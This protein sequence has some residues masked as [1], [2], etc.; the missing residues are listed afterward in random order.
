MVNANTVN[1][2]RGAVAQAMRLCPV[3]P[4]RSSNRTCGFPAS[5]FPAG[6]TS[7]LSAYGLTIQCQAVDAQ[8][9][10]DRFV[11]EASSASRGH[12]VPPGKKTPHV[13][14]HVGVDTPGVHSCGFRSR[15]SC[16]SRARSRS[17]RP[18]YPARREWDISEMIANLLLKPG[19]TLRRRARPQI[20]FAIAPM[21]FKR[22]ATA[23][24]Y[25]SAAGQS[26]S[27]E[28][29]TVPAVRP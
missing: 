5:G 6:F 14:H 22:R 19:D 24:R 10:E 12:F 21:A 1:A 23:R 28:T 4:P 20:Q 26:C 8:L 11:A 7:T 15:S 16:P 27:Q 2:E 18:V 25:L 29:R 3:S 13:L 9:P 17:T